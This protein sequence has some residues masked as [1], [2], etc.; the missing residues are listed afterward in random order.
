MIPATLT[1]TRRYFMA[2]D[3]LDMAIAKGNNERRIVRM[4]Y[5]VECLCDESAAA[6]NEERERLVP[7]MV[8]NLKEAFRGSFIPKAA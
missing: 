2:C 6:L 1:P 3:R 8:A 4:Q 7:D 5:L